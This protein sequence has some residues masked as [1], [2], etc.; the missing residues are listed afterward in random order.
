MMYYGV[1]TVGIGMQ[2]KQDA[3]PNMVIFFILFMIVG[4]L[5]VMNMFVGVVVDTFN[6]QKSKQRNEED[7]ET[8]LKAVLVMKDIE[9]IKK[10]MI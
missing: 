8:N 1:D 5:F 9:I 3:N 2:I 4:A 10:S 6:T 7:T